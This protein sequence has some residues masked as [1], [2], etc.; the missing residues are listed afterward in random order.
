MRQIVSFLLAA[1]LAVMAAAQSDSGAPAAATSAA[2]AA[3]DTTRFDPS[4]VSG[5]ELAGKQVTNPIE[6]INGRVAGL[7]VQRSS[8]SGIAALNAVRLRGTTSLTGGNDPLIIIDGVLGDLKTLQSVNPTD[9][10]S[11]K[12]L[13]DASE[14]AQYGSRGASGVIEV[15]TRRGGVGDRPRI[16]YNG[17]FGFTTAARNLKMLD[18]EGYRQQVIARGLALVD[19]GANTNWQREIERTALLHDHHVAFSGG[20][21]NGGYRVALAYQ[22][23]QGVIRNE[24]INNFT[25]TMRMHQLMFNNLLRIDVGLFG[26]VEKQYTPIYDSQKMFY[27]AQAFNPTYPTTRNRQ[28]G[29]DSYAEASQITHPMALLDARISTKASNLGAHAKLTFN[30]GSHWKLTAFGSY[31]FNET[32]TSHYYPTTIW[33][34]GEAYRGSDKHEQLIGNITA[35]YTV[36][37]GDH[38]LG[39]QA[40]AEVQRETYSG[41]HVTTTNF[42]TNDLGYDA[43]QAGALTLWDGTASYRQ[44]PTQA[45]FM[46]RLTYDYA[47]RYS[48]AATL[49]ADGTS[50]FGNGHKWGCFPSVSASWNIINEPWMAGVKDHLDG[51]KLRVGYGLAGNQGG[52]NS[53]ITM[54]A[55]SPA[56]IVPVGNEAPVSL[57]ALYNTNPDLKWEVKRTFN[58]G[59]DFSLAG[60][61]V[62]ASIDGYTSRTSDLL[63]MYNVGVPPFR[64]TKLLANMG[65]M[66][67]S[68][69]EVSVGVT[70]VATRDWGLNI[71]A[72]VTWQTNK[73]VSLSGYHNGYYLEV[74]TYVD[75][76]G[77]NGAGFHG[78]NNNVTY[79]A[80]GH[81]LGVF[82]LPHCTGLK[83]DG[84]GGYT[85]ELADGGARRVCG[86]AMPKVLMGTNFSL[87]YRH[88]DLSLQINGAFGHKIFNGT[89]LSYMNMNSLPGYNVLAAAPARRIEDQTVSDYWLES[90]NY[91]NLDYITIGWNVP[92]RGKAA[93]IISRLRLSLTAENLA[94]ITGYS[95]LTP[96]INSSSVNKTLGLDDKNI[97]PVTR[98]FTLSLAIGF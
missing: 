95:G 13:K 72:N 39:A 97:Y 33:A 48:L 49:R 46:G 58:I 28:D 73:L 15:T 91:V 34:H 25:S 84:T 78:G 81:P 55:L 66:N 18:A 93:G 57:A 90:G 79:Q 7:T 17:S 80:I 36:K 27:S 3:A 69:L 37:L 38:R 74:P 83:E 16:T 32:E 23:H 8:S 35:D 82:Y 68:G 42:S 96:M 77:M 86:Q 76:A 75:I 85:Y 19:K 10:E 65:K 88:C 14:T 71:N 59:A 54:N 89:A 67:N 41:F 47:D 24:H 43:I 45:S 6:A 22:N 12:V 11:F 21:G 87:R 64:Y 4:R 1:S 29:W 56:G 92:L 60:G 70:P 61:K 30:L 62:V 63:Y 20:A 40:L 26:N 2:A 44:V 94:T 9:I 5:D 31:S 53:Y 50:R 51:L 98:T 52:I